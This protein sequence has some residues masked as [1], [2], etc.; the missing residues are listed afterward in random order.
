MHLLADQ[1]GRPVE[2]LLR[3]LGEELQVRGHRAVLADQR[4]CL[5]LRPGTPRRLAR[6]FL[7]IALESVLHAPDRHAPA[8]QLFGLGVAQRQDFGAGV[9]QHTYAAR[10]DRQRQV[11]VEILGVSLGS[12]Y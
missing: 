2:P 12:Y 11:I 3:R 1:P 10:M 4:V 9:D 8:R 6:L 7:V 5:S